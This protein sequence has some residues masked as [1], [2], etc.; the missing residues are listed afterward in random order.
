MSY[1]LFCYT[2]AT[3]LLIRL[4]AL[5]LVVWH[6]QPL[7]ALAFASYT[8]NRVNVPLL[9]SP[10]L[11]AT[12]PVGGHVV[13]DIQRT[14]TIFL[15]LVVAPG[16]TRPVMP[17]VPLDPYATQTGE[18]TFYGATG[19]GN[20]MFDPTPENLMVA[21]MNHTDYANALLCGAYIEVQGPAG[22][23]MVRIVDRCPEC[24]P[25]D[26]DLSREA[27]ARI[28]DPI[29]GRVP[30]R[31]RII[32]PGSHDL[33]GPIAYRFKEGSNQYWTAIQ[34]RNHRNPVYR[35]E[36]RA[37][38]G[39]FQPLERQEYNYFVAPQGLGPG[40]YTLRVTDI[41]GHTLIDSGITLIEAGM[42]VGSGQFPP[43]P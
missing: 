19:G 33:S 42:I 1:K 7:F 26:V 17:G 36:Y 29:Q 25:G 14:H 13:V 9:S 4:I 40:P 39:S 31:W 20:C 34:V 21:A 3:L 16:T 43:Q 22:T 5:S 28:A 41:Y 15:P 2:P 24:R 27:F 10:K 38:D 32:S 18:G 12:T 37:D 6:V 8:P 23:V 30:I 11:N 35:L